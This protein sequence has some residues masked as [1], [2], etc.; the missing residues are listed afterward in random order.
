MRAIPALFLC[1][2][3]F[4]LA[5]CSNGDK[6]VFPGY[7]E[8]DY[9]RLA[10]PIGG[11]LAKLYLNRGDKV[12]PNAPAFALEQDNERAARTEAA[13]RVQ[14]A[15][16]VLANLRKGKRPDEIAAL[17]AQLNQAQSALRLSTSN[18]A[19]Q[20][21]LVAD[22]FISAAALD[23]ARTA[24]EHDQSQ[25]R[26]MES[27]LRIARQG[28]RP[29]EIRAAEDD[30]NAAKAQLAQAEWKLDQ[31]TLRTPAAADV[32]DVLYREGELVPAGSPVVT[33][34]PPRNIKA[35]FFVAEPV[36]GSIRLGQ[37]V[38][39]RCDGCGNPIPAKIS[40][41]SP[42]AEYTSPLIYSKEN[43]ATLVF[44][45]EARPSPEDAVRL[46][47]GQPLEIRFTPPAAPKASS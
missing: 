12:A 24:V 41:I 1:C 26:E 23:Q 6:D 13:A 43:R 8:G 14:R 36:L 40:F 42:N 44:M 19:R 16:A 47:P 10:S 5:A 3:A 33:L 37:Q 27:Q 9:V 2:S 45:I 39:L 32:V 18:L 15:E 34:L 25:V 7:A 35:R 30:L 28:A 17:Q 11:T 4:A 20:K 31:K 22:K 46:H 38:S 21:Q 29:D